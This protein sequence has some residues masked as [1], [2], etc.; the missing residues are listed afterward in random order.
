MPS[1][2][3]ADQIDAVD[4]RIQIVWP[5]DEAGNFRPATEGTLAN[6]AVT[7]FKHGTRLSV[8]VDWRPAGLTLF[9]AWDQEVGKPLARQAVK[10]TRAGRR[11]HLSRL[12]VPQH[13][14]GTCDR[15]RESAS[16]DHVRR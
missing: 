4:A 8:P 2:I 15:S 5:H 10:Y 16:G 9:G 13:S 12:G 6:I 1:G 11:H 3:A 14:G 7:F